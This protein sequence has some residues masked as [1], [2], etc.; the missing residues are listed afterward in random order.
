VPLLDAVIRTSASVTDKFPGGRP[1][2][3]AEVRRRAPAVFEGDSWRLHVRCFALRSQGQTILVDT[4]IGPE[5]APA[6]TWCGAA[7]ALPAGLEAAD[8]ADQVQLVVITHVHD[9]HLG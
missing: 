4:G 1:Q 6:F 9:D 5:S 7:G 8:R 3:W 2:T